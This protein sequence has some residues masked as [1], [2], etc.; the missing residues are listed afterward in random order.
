L[1]SWIVTDNKGI[2]YYFT[3]PNHLANHYEFYSSNGTNGNLGELNYVSNWHLTKIID[4]LGNEVNF[5]YD[6]SNYT[7]VNKG[8]DN[9]YVYE[10]SFNVCACVE[11]IAT[12]SIKQYSK[13]SLS[14]IS[15]NGVNIQFIKDINNR[16]DLPGTNSLNEI[17][18]TNA[19]THVLK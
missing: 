16:L 12:N 9:A 14:N 8:E 11:F 13:P 10:N 6:T 3:E 1:N 4:N 17:K 2:K 5:S 18:I 19:Y 7:L 15:Y